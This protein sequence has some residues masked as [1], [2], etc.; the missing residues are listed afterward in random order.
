M[1]GALEGRQGGV[2]A[3]VGAGGGEVEGAFHADL[4]HGVAGER[5]RRRRM[6]EA[7]SRDAASA[8][9]ERYGIDAMRTR[10]PRRSNTS[11]STAASTT[12]E[13]SAT[14]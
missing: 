2:V 4:A 10:I 11:R 5:G 8:N 12:G 13:S 1:L 6:R 9:A 14:L 7:V 3:E